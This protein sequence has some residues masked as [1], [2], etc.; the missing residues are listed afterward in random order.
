MKNYIITTLGNVCQTISATYRDTHEEVI[1]INTSDVSEGEIL[2]HSKVKNEK[3]PG[4]FK[5]TFQRNDILYSEIRPANKHFAFVDFSDTRQYIASTKLMV[6]R[7][8]TEMIIPEFLFILLT[9][10]RQLVE[11]QQVAETRSG[12]FPQITFQSE[13]AP[14]KIMLPDI[15]TQEKIVRCIK[16]FSAK[17]KNLSQINHNLEG[18]AA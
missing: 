7:A 8:N 2:N 16:V 17:I 15:Q 5:K 10:P 12:T 3:L 1:L 6:I 11:F 9:S 4:Q 18:I 14:S 13:V